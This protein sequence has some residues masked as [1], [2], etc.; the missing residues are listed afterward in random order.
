M[1]RVGHSIYTG[2][3]EM[4]IYFSSEDSWTKENLGELDVDVRLIVLTYVLGEICFEV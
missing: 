3:K 4:R 1:K 2:I